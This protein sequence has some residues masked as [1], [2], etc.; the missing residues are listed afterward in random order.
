MDG[1]TDAA[2]RF[3]TAKH[4]GP[5]VTL[6]EFV[7]IQSALY[8]PHMLLRDFTYSELERP[9]VAQIYGKTPELFYKVA[10]VVCELGFD[11]L[12]INMGCP[13]KKVAAAGCGAAL[14]RTPD[15]AREIIKAARRGIDDWRNG[16]TLDALDFVP[17]FIA[18][19]KQ[20]NLTRSGR[21]T[22]TERQAIPV[23]IKTRLGYDRIVIEDWLKTLLEEKP[24]AISLHGRTLEQGYKGA[25]NWQAIG[26]AVEVAKGSGTLILGNGDLR[27]LADVCSRIRET[28]VD[29]VLIGRG[30][31]GDP[32]LFRNKSA[33]KQALR[34]GAQF[35]EDGEPVRL[36]ERIQVIIEHSEHFERLCGSARFMAMRKHLTWYCRN[37]RGAAEMRAKMTRANSAEEVRRHLETLAAPTPPA[38]PQLT[39]YAAHFQEH[40]ASL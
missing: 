11:G 18:Q 29:G 13:A 36:D 6:T 24:A 38:R 40:S 4:G 28:G 33:L 30:A 25:A 14:I 15:L 20:T 26:R 7:N 8:S 27:D 37:F 10:H 16:Q 35:S 12:D 32:W 1:I 21:E 22:A 34:E 19:I 2:F 39:E 3:I 23:S 17:E 31:Q 5:D 9:V